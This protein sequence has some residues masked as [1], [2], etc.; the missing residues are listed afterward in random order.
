MERQVWHIL[1][2]E[3]ICRT[4]NVNPEKG[5]GEKEVE[6]RLSH[7]G[8]NVLAEKKGVNPVFLFLGQFKDFMVMVLMV[9]TLISG[10]LG[11]VADAITI[12]AIIFLNAVLGFVQEYKAE[13]SMES[14]RSLTAPEA[15]VVR[16]GLDI[17][18]PA[19]DLVPGDILILEAG[20]RLPADIRWLKTANIRV[21]EAALTGESQA[22]NKTSRSL[23]DEL[24]PMADRRNMGYMGTVIVS[25]HGTG[26]VVATGMKTEMGDIAG[27]IQ[28]VKDEETPL[29]KR[30]DQLGKWL[31][32]ISL[33]V[34]IIV[35]ITGTLQGES[36][37]KMFL[38]GFLWRLRRFLKGCRLL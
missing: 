2:G 29:Q 24:T 22:V 6:R 35:V 23:E 34:C 8:Q 5:L 20:D 33:A 17:R 36:F 19:A 38:P 25:G 7:F 37:S 9:A 1:S 11:E 26:A 27:M 30:L 16:E 10:L 32:T 28:N 31:V 18:I 3:E 12:L 21:D 15:L 4:L 14:L 13:R